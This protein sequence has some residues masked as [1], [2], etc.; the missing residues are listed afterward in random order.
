MPRTVQ[1]SLP[2]CDWLRVEEK[3]LVSTV[4]ILDA[5]PDYSLPPGELSVAFLSHAEMAA[6]HGRFLND[7]TPTD[8][9]TFPGDAEMDFAGEICV[10]VEQAREVAPEHAKSLAEEITLYLVHGWLHLAGLDDRSDEDQLQM[11]LAEAQTLAYLS[12]MSAT[13][14]VELL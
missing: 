9:I 4:D 12:K 6:V 7:Q 10:G 11:R 8:V 5:W 14:P 3:S 2:S 1:L 13:L